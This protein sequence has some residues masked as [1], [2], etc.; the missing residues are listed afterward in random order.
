MDKIRDRWEA[1]LLQVVKQPFSGVER[2]L[3]IVGSDR[4][5]TA[6]GLMRI[7]EQMGVSPWYWWADVP[8]QHHDTV[9]IKVSSPRVD[10]PGVRYRGIFINDEDWGLN[11]WAS[12]T[13]DPQFGNI[14]PKTYEKVF[15]LLLRLRLNYICV[16]RLTAPV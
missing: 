6:Y 11:S 8:A 4:R 2:A 15:E 5:G 14:G 7:S 3:V 16:T 13:F 1:T 9:A 12:K 10:A